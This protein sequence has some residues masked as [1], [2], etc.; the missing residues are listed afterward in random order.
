[1][2]FGLWLSKIERAFS[3]AAAIILFA[4]MAIVAT[5][6]AMRYLLNAP[7]IWSYDLISL[8]L[9]LA[10]FYFA[11]S[12]T[13]DTHGHVG[14][15]ILHYYVTPRV[16]RIFEILTCAVALPLFA[17][18]TYAG[19]VRA[20]AAFAASDVIAGLIAWPTWI[21]IALVPLGAG[22]LTLRLAVN[23]AAHATALATGVDVIPLPPLARSAEGGSEVFE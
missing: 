12:R 7:F 1:M 14:V 20:A 6:V 19:V 22:L 18:M 15:D 8:Y 2:T 10:L 23:L 3:I 17:L 5:D 16:R 13:F 9:E 11:L 4:I 21:S